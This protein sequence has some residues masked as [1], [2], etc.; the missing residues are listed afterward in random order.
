MST[1]PL[2]FYTNPMS[3]GRMVRWMLEECAASYETVVLDYGT[4][5][6]EAAY[7]A[8]NP[9][10]KVPAIRHGEVVVTETAAICA[11]LADQFPLRQLAPAL[12][13]PDRGSY[14]RWLFYAAGVVEPAVTAKALG[15]LAPEDKRVMAGY[16]SYDD[17]IRVLEM[18]TTQAVR[19]GG[20]VCGKHFTAADLYLASQLGW[21]MRFDIIEKKPVFED[22]VHPLMQR[23]A[24]LRADELDT[25]LLPP[26]GPQA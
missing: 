5:M 1:L 23:P 26:S 3:R 7:L 14:Y 8:V 20:H 11:Y 16:G 10:G 24:K 12:S 18:V 15:L 2:T 4:S 9:M 25:A 19:Q 13:S 17:V 22:Y 6:K 21:G